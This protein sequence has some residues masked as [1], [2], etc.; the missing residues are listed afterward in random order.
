MINPVDHQ[1]SMAK[2]KDHK[3]SAIRQNGESQN[4]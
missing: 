4:P 1:F 2:H 3:P